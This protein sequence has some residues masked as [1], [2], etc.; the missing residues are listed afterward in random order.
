[1]PTCS[2]LAPY[3][4]AALLGGLTAGCVTTTRVAQTTAAAPVLDVAKELAYCAAQAR[5]TVD[6]KSNYTRQ[7]RRIG[8]GKAQWEY[9]SREDWTSGF[10]PGTL[11]YVYETQPTA[12][13]KE[14]A[15]GFTQDLAPVLDHKTVDHDLGFQFYCSYGNGYRLT[16]DPAYKQVLLRAADSLAMLFNPRVGTILSWP[17]MVK[18]MNWP[19]NTIMDNMIN[20]ELLF[21][22]SKHGGSKKLYDMAVSHAR[23]TSRNHFRPDGTSYHVAVYDDKTGQF[24]KGVTHQGYADNTMWARGQAWAIYGFTMAYRESRESE[25][26]DR[27]RKSADI[28]IQRLPADQVPY[29]DFDA[30]DI[31]NA[32]RDASA[33]AVVASALLELST[34]VPDKAAAQGYRQQAERMLVTLSSAQYQAR[35]QSPAFLLHSTGHKPNGTEIDASINYADYYYLEALLRLQKLQQNKSLSV[36]EK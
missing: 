9:V 11:W 10:W 21:W 23:V 16:K 22:A 2:R 17:R 34:L 12:F 20:L 13:W 15:Q 26:L 8:A 4:F 27:A 28:F 24:I 18:Q 25:F 33:A 36:V 29:W 3:F 5:K 30:P 31:P 35:D 14:K 19:H 32:P 7:P 6:Q 1:M